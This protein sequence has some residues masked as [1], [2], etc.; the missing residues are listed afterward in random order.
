MSDLDISE[1]ELYILLKPMFEKVHARGFK[2]NREG[3][4][5]ANIYDMEYF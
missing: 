1:N 4:L 3:N 2:I 5:V